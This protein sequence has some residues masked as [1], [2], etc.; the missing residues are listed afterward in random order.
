MV[1]VVCKWCR[2]AHTKSQKRFER[3]ST[4]YCSPGCHKRHR[5]FATFCRRLLKPKRKRQRQY[6]AWEL[7]LNR[8]E[9]EPKQKDG[10]RSVI[11]VMVGTSQ[12]ASTTRQLKTKRKQDRSKRD[13][14]L[15]E[16]YQAGTT[17][18]HN[19]MS[20]GLSMLSVK[21]I[22]RRM[23]RPDIKS[24]PTWDATLQRLSIGQRKDADWTQK[25][26]NIVSAHLKRMDR[27]VMAVR[28]RQ[29]S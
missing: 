26:R 25:L 19:A 5:R 24:I 20:H 2:T 13:A 11:W 16:A 29:Q 22:V 8:C 9:K 6:D 12:A 3:A 17:H 7:A 10:W 23:R 18:R 4:H 21:Q 15:Y 28:S 14:V 1:N 27:K